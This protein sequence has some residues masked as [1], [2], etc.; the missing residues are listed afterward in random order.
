MKRAFL[1]F[2]AL[3]LSH[4]AVA[5]DWTKTFNLTAKPDLRVE[6]S[7]A[8]L[9]VDTWDQNK[10]EADVHVYGYKIGPGGIDIYDHQTGNSV[11][12]EVRY[13]HEH[14][15]IGWEGHGHRVEIEV[16]MPREGRVDLHTGDGSIHLAGLKGDMNVTT[17]DGS[18]E[19]ENVDGSL[20]ARA[21]DGHIHASGRFDELQL[22]TGDG[23]IE[24]TAEANSNIAH[25][26]EVQTG[27][28]SVN[29]RIPEKLAANVDFATH[30]G[31]LDV[32]MPVTVTG[33]LKENAIRG[34]MNGG[35]NLLIIHTGDGSIRVERT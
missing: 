13:P 3:L 23:T 1:L 22:R 9:T 35:G 6:T 16:H 10:I 11:A 34:T 33:R 28:G 27:D 15:H 5:E 25:E 18:Q 7:D 14:F 8:K 2:A 4:F 32:D 21:G 24:A 17:G 29:L 19:I 26:W 12:I 30:D 31:H 20:H